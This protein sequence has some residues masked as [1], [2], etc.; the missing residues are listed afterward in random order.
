M[1]K[2]VTL[3]EKDFIAASATAASKY[4]GELQEVAK[5][6]GHDVNPKTLL[7]ETLSCTAFSGVLAEVLFQK[8]TEAN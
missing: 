2:T 6:R 8:E 3:T 5:K 7:G 4:L 1:E